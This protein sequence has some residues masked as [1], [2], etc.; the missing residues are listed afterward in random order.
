MLS[1]FFVLGEDGV[2]LLE[3]EDGGVI[4]GMQIHGLDPGERSTELFNAIGYEDGDVLLRIN[5]DP[6]R[7]V[8]ERAFATDQLLDEDSALV[9]IQRG[10]QKLVCH[11]IEHELP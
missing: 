3:F 2:Q 9:H 7:T 11:V 4:V 8:E 5:N 6:L 10:G 1:N